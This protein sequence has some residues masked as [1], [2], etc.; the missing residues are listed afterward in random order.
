MMKRRAEKI[1][2]S[3]LTKAIQKRQATP[4]LGFLRGIIGPVAG[5]LTYD[6]FHLIEAMIQELNGA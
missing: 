4:L 3:R 1:L 6:D 5:L 2:S